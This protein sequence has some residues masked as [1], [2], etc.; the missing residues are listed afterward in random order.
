MGPNT[1]EEDGYDDASKESACGRRARPGRAELLLCETEVRGWCTAPEEE[2][3]DD[4]D[5]TKDKPLG[6][7]NIPYDDD[8]DELPASRPPARLLETGILGAR[9]RG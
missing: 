5:E 3:E 8:D 1:E 7:T 2:E 4:D 6:G 9:R